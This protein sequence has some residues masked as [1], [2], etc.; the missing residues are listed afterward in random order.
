METS[1][2]SVE[3]IDSR[4]FSEPLEEHGHGHHLSHVPFYAA[5]LGIGVWSVLAL[6]YR[7]AG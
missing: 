3:L 4:S 7:I 5:V 2:L 6:L 1:D